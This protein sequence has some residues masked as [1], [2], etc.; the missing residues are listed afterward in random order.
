MEYTTLTA[1]AREAQVLEPNQSQSLYEICQ[2]LVDGRAERGKQY[3]LAGLL[4]V[5][6]LPKLA[7]QLRRFSSH[8]DE[9]L[10]WVL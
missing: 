9:A 7:R 2:Q 1:E 5:L 4:V 10:A 3:D 6:V 8:P